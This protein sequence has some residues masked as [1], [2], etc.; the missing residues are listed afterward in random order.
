MKKLQFTSSANKFVKEFTKMNILLTS[1]SR[2]LEPQAKYKKKK[3]TE[4]S[5][6]SDS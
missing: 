1:L 5:M 6:C 2:L 3:K 4:V